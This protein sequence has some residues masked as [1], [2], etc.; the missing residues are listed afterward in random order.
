MSTTP[1]G[2][3]GKPAPPSSLDTQELSV[4]RPNARSEDACT[5][6]RRP[7]V[8]WRHSGWSRI[9]GKVYSALV[10]TGASDSRLLRFAY[11]GTGAWV[12]KSASTPSRYIVRANYCHDRLCR[13]C[14]T[15]KAI[16]VREALK[17]MVNKPNLK[18][19]TL[20]LRHTD[21]PLRDQIRRLNSSFRKLRSSKFW[22]SRVT[23]GV[24]FLEL[25]RSKDGER[26]HP[27]Y[28]IIL[29][30]KYFPQNELAQLWLK[31]TG[32]SY[33]VDIRKIQSA[34]EATHYATKYVTKPIPSKVWNNLDHACEA[35]AA[36]YRTRTMTC[37]GKWHGIKIRPTFS[38]EIWQPVQPLI[39]VI[40]AAAAGV[41]AAKTLMTRLRSPP[42]CQTSKEPDREK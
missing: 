31:C 6:H 35:V 37:F 18:F 24:A 30:S 1:L 10:N 40:Q 12:Y 36:L 20:T 2:L 28:H 42:K 14:A 4:D 26:W 29:D 13:P 34:R 21:T 8:I 38:P 25:K 17:P 33:I 39:R 11:C 3:D 7:D 22:R 32:D 41:V 16:R 5:G 15:A 9:R 23:G 27:H 19:V